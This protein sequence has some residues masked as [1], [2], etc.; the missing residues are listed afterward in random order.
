MTLGSPLGL[1]LAAK[2]KPI[3]GVTVTTHA[4][5]LLRLEFEYVVFPCH[6]IGIDV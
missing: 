2:E 5:V 6:S 4:S 3:D 1:R